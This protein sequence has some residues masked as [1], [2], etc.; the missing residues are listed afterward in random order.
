MTT[1]SGIRV[2]SI[3]AFTRVFDALYA[4]TTAGANQTNFHII[5]IM[6]YR[7]LLVTP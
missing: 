5:H 3:S 6:R 4:E 1:A 7:A 2:P